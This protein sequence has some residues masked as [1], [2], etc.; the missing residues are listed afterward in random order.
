MGRLGVEQAFGEHWAVRAGYAYGNNPVPDGTLTPLTAAITEHLL[1]LGRGLQD[2]P[3][4]LRRRV[5]MAGPGDGA[6]GPQRSGGGG[7]L[8]QRDERVHPGGQPL[9]AGGVLRGGLPIAM[10][11]G[12]ARASSQ[13][14]DWCA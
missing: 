1:T 14:A 9:G 8:R 7:I 3:L 4:A 11:K 13:A 2:G 6:G 10:R 12:F 5:P